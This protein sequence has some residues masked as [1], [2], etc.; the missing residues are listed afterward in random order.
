M[1][2][3]SW[4]KGSWFGFY[5]LVS[6]RYWSVGFLRYFNLRNIIFI[7]IGAPAVIVGGLGLSYFSNS[8]N[9]R[10]KGLYLSFLVLFMITTF[11]TNIQS[12]TRFFC[13]HPYFYYIMTRLSMKLKV[14]RVWALFY[15]LIGIF[16]Y[17]VGFPWT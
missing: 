1:C 5:G 6:D 14:V 10:K 17:V 13:G 2:K 7:I 11:F 8:F 9:L 4:Y 3:G 16:M 12:S 15:W